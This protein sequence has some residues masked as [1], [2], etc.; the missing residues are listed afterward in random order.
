M[1]K[2]Q[3]SVGGLK[4][5]LKIQCNQEKKEHFSRKEDFR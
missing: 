5:I 4:I 3:E 2:I 1:R